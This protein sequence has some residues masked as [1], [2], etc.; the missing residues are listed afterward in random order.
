MV[1]RRRVG[2]HPFPR[3]PA[4]AARAARAAA[5]GARTPGGCEV[6]LTTLPA[7]PPISRTRAAVG[8]LIIR[9][10]LDRLPLQVRMGPDGVLGRGGPSMAVHDPAAF[11]RRI[12]AEGLIGFGESYVAG[13]WDARDPVAVLT[14]LAGH[15]SALVPAPLQRLRG[16]W[17][18][19]QPVEQRNTRS[20]S[21]SNIERHYDL[22]N[23]LFAEFL[24]PTMSYS[25]AVFRALPARPADLAAA[26]HRKIDM[27]LDLAGVG[28]DVRLLEIGTG[29]GELAI[30][31]AGRG[32]RVVTLTLSREQQELARERIAAAGLADRVEVRLCDYREAR[33]WYDAIV[34]VEMIEAVGAEYWPVYFRTLDRLLEPGGRVALQAITMPHE[35]MLATKDTYTWI[36]KY[37]FPGGM[38]PS[39]RAVEETARAH[40][41][42]RVVRC[43]GYGAH[44]A[45]TL[46][47]WRE[48]FEER[49]ERVA[50]LGFDERF[51]RMWTF[52]LA[53]CEAGFAS[54][55]LDVHQFLLTRDGGDGR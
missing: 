53:Y 29:W 17:A 46:R 11:E 20:G 25:S 32:A 3:H 5:A 9:R 10:A 34:S 47:L 41:R 42:L 6:T 31:A 44:Y 12:A 49:A 48:R 35:R 2:G 51:R 19:R 26:Q 21:R 55:Y 14:V 18:A 38:L 1:H 45:Q 13:E 4:V 43:E 50:E 30:R 16:L 23:E 7:V 52:Y 15:V 37:I 36:Q 24:D 40:G 8:R 33:G 39:V 27:L 28:P 22:S 54:G